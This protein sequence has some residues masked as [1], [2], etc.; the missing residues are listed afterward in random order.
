MNCAEFTST[1]SAAEDEEEEEEQKNSAR[2]KQNSRLK[3]KKKCNNKYS[4]SSPRVLV[5]H[6][7]SFIEMSH[8]DF[9]V[10]LKD[11]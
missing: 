6:L 7:S 2:K 3:Y 4:L 10:H 11:D 8:T 1:V 5:Q 9:M